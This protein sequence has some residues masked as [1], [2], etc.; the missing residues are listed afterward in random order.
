[1][2]ESTTTASAAGLRCSPLVFWYDQIETDPMRVE[3]RV[4][5]LLARVVLRGQWLRHYPSVDWLA[6]YAALVGTAALGWQ[7]YTWWTDRRLKVKVLAHRLEDHSDAA[8]YQ[9]FVVADVVN[10]GTH[11][12]RVVATTLMNHS[13]VHPHGLQRDPEFPS[14]RASPRLLEFLGT[15]MALA[16]AVGRLGN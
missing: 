10:L 15:R 1:L 6:F 8:G 2:A 13:E 16:F 11:P 9:L 4:P 12:V 7:V 14:V 5:R 3:N